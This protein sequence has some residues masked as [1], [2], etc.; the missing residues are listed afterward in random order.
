MIPS[1]FEAVCVMITFNVIGAGRLG[2]A[3]AVTLLQEK[4]NELLGVCN[5]SFSS[6][7]QAVLDM[8]AGV[9][10]AC[11]DD[12]PKADITFITTPDDA[13]AEIAVNLAQRASLLNSQ[14]MVHCSGA[15]NSDVLQPLKKRGYDV[16]SAHPLKAFGRNPVENAFKDCPWGLEGDDAAIS[17]L[18]PILQRL[19][20]KPFEIQADKKMTYHAA[21]VMA[22]NFVVTLASAAETLFANCGLTSKEAKSV[23][24]FLMQSSFANIIASHNSEEALTGPLMRGD[25]ETISKH[26]QA[27]DD[28]AIKTLYLSA[29]LATLP[30]TPLT[31]EKKALLQRLLQAQ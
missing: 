17:R 24:Q 8:D 20:A 21:A 3:L 18:T 23:T 9:A 16:C 11:L 27:L 15:L 6:T 25:V 7:R 30:L 1:L 10:Y 28:Q 26:L 5:R 29:S 14:V 22:S 4:G 19:G 2:K 12:L 31:T 13:I